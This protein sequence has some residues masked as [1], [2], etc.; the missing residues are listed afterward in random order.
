MSERKSVLEPKPGVV[1]ADAKLVPLLNWRSWRTWG[2]FAGLALGLGTATGIVTLLCVL[3]AAHLIDD[4]ILQTL[5]AALAAVGLCMIG[6]MALKRAIPLRDTAGRIVAGNPRLDFPNI[7]LG[8]FLAA[9]WVM[10]FIVLFFAI[11]VLFRDLAGFDPENFPF[12]V[13][14]VPVFIAIMVFEVPFRVLWRAPVKEQE[15]DRDD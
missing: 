6:V 5:A 12:W 10:S 14:S 1:L 2:V 3:A 15:P 11:F 4:R 13:V 7:P 9:G 8:P